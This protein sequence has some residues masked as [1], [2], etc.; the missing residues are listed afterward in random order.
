MD[1]SWHDVNGYDTVSSGC[2][3]N[4]K[5]KHC[6]PKG[7]ILGP[8]SPRC[9]I[10]LLIDFKRD[11]S[12]RPRRPSAVPEDCIMRCMDRKMCFKI[13]IRWM[14]DSPE[15]AIS[16]GCTQT[17]FM[18]TWAS[19]CARLI[20]DSKLFDVELNFILHEQLGFQKRNRHS[21][22]QTSILSTTTSTPRE[23]QKRL[24]A[25]MKLYRM[26]L[27]NCM[28]FDIAA[29]RRGDLSSMIWIKRGIKPAPTTM[30]HPDA[31]EVMY[32]M[33]DNNASMN[34]WGGFD[35]GS[36][37]STTM[38]RTKAMSIPWLT[39]ALT[40]VNTSWTLFFYLA[41]A[42]NAAMAAVWMMV[43]M[44]WSTC[45][46]SAIWEIRSGS[47]RKRDEVAWDSE[48]VCPYIGMASKWA[49]TNFSRSALFPADNEEAD[50]IRH[51]NSKVLLSGTEWLWI[52]S[53]S[54]FI[55][56]FARIVCSSSLIW[57]AVDICVDADIMDHSFRRDAAD[58][59]G[60]SSNTFSG[61]TLLDVSVR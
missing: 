32:V 55:T 30:F 17:S 5:Y 1:K 48:C 2:F 22:G 4:K 41:S 20:I 9:S 47:Y 33:K 54:T 38:L 52:V 8:K 7:N 35:S 61:P 10:I 11:I 6:S 42:S 50:R 51:N 27:T 14:S 49:T 16:G 46:S 13:A 56:G 39:P 29:R 57:T 3:E 31:W 18:L 40:A 23:A 19:D 36:A 45:Q 44:S 34:E 53:A 37:T 59:S 21:E 26:L 12:I 60:D 28:I 58:T 15:N 25:F 43:D 24:K